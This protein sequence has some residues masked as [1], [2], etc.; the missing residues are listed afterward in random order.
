MVT[1][2]FPWPPV[3]GGRLLVAETLRA[4]DPSQVRVTLIGPWDDADLP[5]SGVAKD[6]DAPALDRIEAGGSD[7]ARPGVLKTLLSGVR[8][9]SALAF[10]SFGVKAPPLTALKHSSAS[11]RGRIAALLT[12]GDVDVIHVEQPH[13]LGSVPATPV[14]ILLRAQNVEADLWHRYA[15]AGRG[16]KRYLLHQQA[17]A[18]ER[19]E[20]RATERAY[21]VAAISEEDRA[22]FARRYPSLEASRLSAVP[23]AFPSQVSAPLAERSADRQLE[24][25]PPVV[26]LCGSSWRPNRLGEN[27]FLQA[28]WPLMQRREPGAVLHAFSATPAA[29][30]P[31]G[32]RAHPS[33]AASED[34]LVAGAVLAVPATVTS[35]VRMKILEAIA[36][37]LCVITTEAGARG[38]GPLLRQQVLVAKDPEQWA[39]HLAL[40]AQPEYYRDRI[41]SARDALAREHNPALVAQAFMAL[42]R[43][44]DEL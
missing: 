30:L 33:P 26:A 21:L 35:G 24:G 19:W 4:F 42:Y 12:Q 34:A 29:S 2:K 28:C 27:H 9:T 39:D 38:L 16:P 5:A 44:C 23:P 36:R 18:V 15:Q 14:P 6:N 31:A 41:T 32:A 37:G 22:S 7:E 10:A 11:L 13:A 40:C 43:Q 1:T 8:S 17:R 20:R 3:D 25:H